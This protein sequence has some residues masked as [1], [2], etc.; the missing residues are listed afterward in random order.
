MKLKL[1]HYWRSSASWRVRWAF[2]IKKI[3]CEFVSINLLEGEQKRPE[4][5]ERNPNGTVPVLEIVEKGKSRFLSESMAIMEW[6][7]EL[8]PKPSLLPGDAYQ[9]GVIRQLAE[10]INS[11][12]HPVQNLR[13]RKFYSQNEEKQKEWATHWICAGF[14]AYEKWM[15]QTAGRFSVGDQITMADLCLIPQCYNAKRADIALETFPT[16]AKI[17]AAAIATP[18]CKAASPEKFQ[19]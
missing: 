3:A 17:Y 5:L 4:Y 15:R 7:E 19:P 18:E 14:S 9:K 10:V 12:I 6:A 1:Y 8:F 2:A 13:V 11:G 16:I